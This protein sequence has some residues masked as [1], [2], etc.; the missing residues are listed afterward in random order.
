MRKMKSA[1]VLH[2]TDEEGKAAGPI[3]V[4]EGAWIVPSILGISVIAVGLRG[5]TEQE[6]RL[7]SLTEEERKVAGL[8]FKKA[9]FAS[10]P[11]GVI[12]DLCLRFPWEHK[13]FQVARRIE[14]GRITE[15]PKLTVIAESFTDEEKG[16]H[17]VSMKDLAGV[18]HLAVGSLFDFYFYTANDAYP[19]AE[20]DHYKLRLPVRRFKDDEVLRV[21]RFGR[22][23]RE[24]HT[25]KAIL[26]DEMWVPL[27]W[28]RNVCYMHGYGH[29][30][31]GEW[32][33]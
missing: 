25:R 32:S 29:C 18:L 6:G 7:V 4:E 13:K 27:E 28:A 22:T 15:P 24:E 11:F 17:W 16:L 12:H 19:L 9:M 23:G 3:F 21:D 31:V 33:S 26:T 14:N 10:E 20:D 2:T 30:P 1:Y 5:D 8:A